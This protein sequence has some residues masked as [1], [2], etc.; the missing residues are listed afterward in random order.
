MDPH[1]VWNKLASMHKEG[2]I[3]TQNII[4]FNTIKGS[5]NV[6]SSMEINDLHHL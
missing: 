1:T 6:Q 2:D 5:S 4:R 3:L